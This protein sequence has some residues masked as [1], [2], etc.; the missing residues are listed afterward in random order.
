MGLPRRN[1]LAAQHLTTQ[2]LDLGLELVGQAL[3]I[4]GTV[5]YHRHPFGFQV[6]QRILGNRRPHARIDGAQAE[7]IVIAQTGVHRIHRHRKLWHAGLID[8]ARGRN[9]GARGKRADHGHHFFIEQTLCGQRRLL[10]IF[11][12][13]LRHQLKRHRL[14]IDLACAAVQGID[15]QLRAVLVVLA[16]MRIRAGQ[17]ADKTD[18]HDIGGGH[19]MQASQS[20]SSH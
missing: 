11:L 5:I 18:F 10:G 14:A 8:D 15:G 17:G 20:K 2:P 19:R 12:V 3:T 7:Y 1:I 6:G 9:G 4:G 13:V 16:P